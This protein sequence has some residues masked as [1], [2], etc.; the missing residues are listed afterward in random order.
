[1][2]KIFSIVLLM[3]GLSGF[4]QMVPG[5]II[6][7]FENGDARELSAYFN[8]NLELQLPGENHVT[9]KNQATR[10][11]QDFFKENEPLS[12]KVTYE[13]KKQDSKYGLGTLVTRKGTFR[14]NIY[15]MEGKKE[16]TIYYLS[17]EKV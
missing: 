15:F 6:H 11:M 16:Q 7:A 13:G 5:G 3:A 8:E 2:K 12:F 4:S 9:S 17:I 14:I 10:I 1:M